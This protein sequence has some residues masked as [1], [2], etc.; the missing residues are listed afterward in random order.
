MIL[1]RPRTKFEFRFYSELK[2]GVSVGDELLQI[3]VDMDSPLSWLQITLTWI[4]VGVN[5]MDIFIIQAQIS[6]RL[7][8]K[9]VFTLQIIYGFGISNVNQQKS[10]HHP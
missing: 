7:Y 5:H 8:N 4:V 1:N 2:L 10:S 3:A 6:Y 9:I